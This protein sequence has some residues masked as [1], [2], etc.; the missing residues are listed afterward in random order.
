M[1]IQHFKK[2]VVND[3]LQIKKETVLNKTTTNTLKVKGKSE[4]CDDTQVNKLLVKN[5]TNLKGK[6]TIDANLCVNWNTNLKNKTTVENLC[7]KRM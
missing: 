6:T 7:I 4:L 5:E 2:T 3:D 1:E